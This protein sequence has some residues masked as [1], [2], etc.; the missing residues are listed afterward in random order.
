MRSL[1][2]TQRIAVE[3]DHQIFFKSFII[4]DSNSSTF[5]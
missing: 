3:N 4:L 2:E 1:E 5:I